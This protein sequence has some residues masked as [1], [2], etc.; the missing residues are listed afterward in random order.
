M[1]EVLHNQTPVLGGAG[2]IYQR[3]A[4]GPWY[5]YFW[6]K[7]ERKRFRQSLETTDKPLAIRTAE[8]IV[9]DA[10]ARQQAGQKVLSASIGEV[11]A[12]WEVL[13]ND[14]LARGEIRSADYVRHLASVFR[15]Q[16]GGLYGLDTP[17]SALKQEDWDRYVPYRGDQGGRAGHHQGRV[18]PHQGTGGQ[19]RHKARCPL[20]A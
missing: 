1:P 6:L 20:G 2:T 14:R 8:Q 10:L 18:L 5:L 12:K 17:I 11:I 4:E 16:L 13:Q 7:A 3:K 9:L 19:G 15:K